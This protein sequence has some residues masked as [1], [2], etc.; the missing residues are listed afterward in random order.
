MDNI[1][2]ECECNRGPKTGNWKIQSE[3]LARHKVYLKKKYKINHLR[4]RIN[5]KINRKYPREGKINIFNTFYSTC[6]SN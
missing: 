2:R 5:F 1:A 3:F 4:C 6:I